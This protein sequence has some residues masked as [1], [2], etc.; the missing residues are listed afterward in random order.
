MRVLCVVFSEPQEK[1]P[2]S[3]RSA[4][5]FLLPPRQRTT[6]TSGWEES[7]VFAGWRPS[8]YLEERRG[9]GSVSVLRTSRTGGCARGAERG[10]E[11]WASGRSRRANPA[12]RPR[13]T[14]KNSDAPETTPGAWVRARCGLGM[15]THFLF[16]RQGFCLP[17]VARRLWSE[18]R[19]IPVRR[20]GQMRGSARVSARLERK[21]VHA[22][23]IPAREAG[24]RG[25]RD[26]AGRRRPR[27]GGSRTHP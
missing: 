5:N 18:S 1:L 8:S 7:L 14:L 13:V 17:P 20:G 22:G 4:R 24:T 19:E 2:V 3:R 12:R 9:K 15:C 27:R 25:A 21:I 10:R 11:A 26:R 6:R 23:R 16:L